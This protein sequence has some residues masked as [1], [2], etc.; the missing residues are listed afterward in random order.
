[1][2]SFGRDSLMR[3]N[4]PGR[5]PKD[6]NLDIETEQYKDSILTNYRYLQIAWTERYLQRNV[7]N[8]AKRSSCKFSILF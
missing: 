8:T 5:K 6:K 3:D 1:M 4:E 2:W 7:T